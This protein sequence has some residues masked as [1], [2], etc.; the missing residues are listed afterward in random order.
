MFVDNRS[1]KAI[2]L[3]IAV[4]GLAACGSREDVAEDVET[5]S[6]PDSAPEYVGESERSEPE[7]GAEESLVVSGAGVAR[8]DVDS[9]ATF[10]DINSVDVTKAEADF[11]SP[12]PIETLGTVNNLNA[13]YP[14]NWVVIHD[15]NFHSMIDGRFV[16]FDVSAEARGM[17][18]SFHGGR[19]GGF[20]ISQERQEAYVAT[21]Y[22]SRGITGERTDI[23]AVHDL[24]TFKKKAEMVLPPILSTMTPMK[25]RVRLSGDESFAFA[26]NFTPASS[27]SVI[28]VDQLTVLNE[29]QIPGCALIYPMGKRGFASVCGDGSV[30][31]FVLD[32][33][34]KVLSEHRTDKIIDFDGNAMFMKPA[35]FGTTLNFPTFQGDMHQFDLSNGTPKFSGSWSLTTP[36]ERE[37]NWRPGGWQLVTA[38]EERGEIFVLMHPE[39][40]EGTHKNPGIEIWVFDEKTGDRKRK[41]EL[42]LPAVSIVATRDFLVATN[43]E[44][45]LDVYRLSD[46]ALARTVGGAAHTPLLVYTSDAR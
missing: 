20:E 33:A 25:N 35:R 30:S 38:H 39:G 2:A 42:S 17:K 3:I 5:L 21:T 1:V 16:V 10:T 26:Y 12:L 44:M 27:V 29:V 46:G 32:K 8:M 41:I 31:G 36:E 40:G 43:V 18:G 11:S 22:H 28:D 15:A 19:I 23:L 37:Q 13:P 34:G 7:D 14:D 6:N 45:A 24:C 4:I 9:C